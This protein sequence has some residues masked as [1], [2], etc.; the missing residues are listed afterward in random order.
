MDGSVS[1]AR[2]NPRLWEREHY[3]A[4]WSPEKPA[5]DGWAA[6]DAAWMMDRLELPSERDVAAAWGWR[7]TRTAEF[8]A[9]RLAEQIEDEPREEK[10]AALALLRVPKHPGVKS[11]QTAA[12]THEV[13]Q[14]NAGQP[15]K[16][17]GCES[18]EDAAKE[19]P[20]SG[21]NAAKTQ[22]RAR[23]PQPT[24]TATAEGS[25]PEG[26]QAPK[27]PAPSNDV[28]ELYQRFRDHHPR[29]SAAPTTDGRKAITRILAECLSVQHA[30]IYLAWVAASGDTPARQ[31][32][33]DAPWP[34]GEHIRRDDLESLSRHIGKRLPL[35]LAW[36]ARGRRDGPPPPPWSGA[37]PGKPP[38][39]N[40]L[41]AT[42]A[43]RQERTRRLL[44]EPEIDPFAPSATSRQLTG[45]SP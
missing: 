31:L 34:D 29:A 24:A 11:G 17:E 6:A 37:P 18:V 20:I 16:D 33:G 7:R 28:S 25:P 19:Q 42:E 26:G 32:R 39:S 14:P 2:L 1:Y 21:Q 43:D 5:S 10:R 36:E 30:T 15:V 44:A 22:P 12:K 3:T 41:A 4:Q 45:K 13:A 23:V 40:R 35:A 38:P 8:L 9:A 27:V